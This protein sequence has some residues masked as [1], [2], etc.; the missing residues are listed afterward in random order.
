MLK[1]KRKLPKTSAEWPQPPRNDKN[2]GGMQKT[3]VHWCTTAA[4]CLTTT[5]ECKKPARNGKNRSGMEHDHVVWHSAQVKSSLPRY[6]AR[7]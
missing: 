1:T 7:S 3:T 4:Q 2:H 6:T 5:A